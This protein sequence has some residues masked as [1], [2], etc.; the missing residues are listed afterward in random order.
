VAAG[1]VI[2]YLSNSYK[3]V[4]KKTAEQLIDEFGAAGVFTALATQPDRV[5]E[6]L[7]AGRRTDQLIEAWEA[8]FERRQARAG[9]PAS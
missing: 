2:R 9:T 1:A 7:G 3:G 4:G 5:R 8:D 6:V